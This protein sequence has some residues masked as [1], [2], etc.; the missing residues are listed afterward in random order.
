M[1]VSS[2]PHVELDRRHVEQSGPV[3]LVADGIL[4][5]REGVF[6]AEE[7]VDRFGVAELEKRV[8]AHGESVLRSGRGG[9]CPK[10]PSAT[11]SR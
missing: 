5:R 1:P 3:G 4:E 2:Y 9:S 7:E 11:A 6:L 10:Q 8:G